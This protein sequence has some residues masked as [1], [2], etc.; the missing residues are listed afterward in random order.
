MPIQQAQT[1]AVTVFCGSSSGNQPAF[2]KAAR[3]LGKALA[4]AKRPLVYGGGSKGIMGEVSGAVLDAGGDV[5]GIVPYAMVSAG[6]E[7]DQTKGVHAPHVQLKEKG[8]E[9]ADIIVVNS[10]HERK[11]EMA[12]RSCGFVGLPGGYGTYEEVLE[13]VCWSQIGIH[14]KPVLILNVLNFY[15]PLRD[16]IRN[17]IKNGFIRDKNEQLVLF[18]EGPADHVEHEDFDWGKAAVEALDRWQDVATSHYYNW[19]L[20]KDGKTD[21]DVLGA[22]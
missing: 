18:V 16:L 22:S 12:R 15:D 9:R 17:G 2:A 8:R 21:E 13:V 20:R 10:M 3:S 6:G 19:T 7:V 11:A 14:S 4:E 5:T 1:R